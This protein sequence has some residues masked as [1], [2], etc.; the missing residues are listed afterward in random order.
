MSK[1]AKQVTLEEL[2]NRDYKYGFKTDIE[3]VKSIKG[4]S[5]ATIRMISEYK[6]EPE[7]MLEFRLKAYQQW[8]KMKEPK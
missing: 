8:L 5:E 2:V 6:K 1:E 3:V 4:L 7:W